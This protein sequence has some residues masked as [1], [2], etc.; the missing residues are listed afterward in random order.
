MF[1]VDSNNTRRESIASAWSVVSFLPIR[2]PGSIPGGVR[3]FNFYPGAGRVSFVY[4][5]SCV[6][7][8]CGPDIRLT[9]DFREARL[10][11]SV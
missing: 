2:R 3:N 1:V 5:L 4:V 7:S 8:S 11:V 9:T 6:V 10:C